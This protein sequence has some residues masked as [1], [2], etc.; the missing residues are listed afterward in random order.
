VRIACVLVP[1][2]PVVVELLMQP[3]LRGCPVV[4]GGAPEDRKLVVECSS[5]AERAG[6]RR[7]M[8]IREALTRCPMPCFLKPDPTSTPTFL[9]V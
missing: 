2:F 6:V 9:I 8:P 7:D 4:L 5:E 1:R 3:E